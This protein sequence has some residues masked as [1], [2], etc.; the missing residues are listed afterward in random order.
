[1]LDR[2]RQQEHIEL[3]FHQFLDQ[4]LGLRLADLQIKITILLTNQWQEGRQNVRCEGWYDAK[5]E[6]AA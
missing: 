2:Q 6:P 1:M 5:P 4:R 3:A